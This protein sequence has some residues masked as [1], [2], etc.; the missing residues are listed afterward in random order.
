MDNY[1]RRFGHDLGNG[2]YDF[3][4]ARQGTIVGLLSIGCLFGAL[5]AGRLADT[6]GRRLAISFFAFFA[7]IGTAIEISSSYHW[8]QFAMGRFVTGI[9]IG[10]MSVVVPMYQSESTPAVIRGV[11]VSSY[12]LLITLGIWT[13][14]MVNYGTNE[15][16]SSAS[17]RI[18]NG[19][20]FAWALVLGSTILFLPESPRY[21]YSR[22]RIEE[23]RETIAKLVGLPPTSNVV[24]KQIAD[25]QAK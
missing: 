24:N 18:P 4:A 11:I 25:L 9:S 13:A 12:Q 16:E 14:E 2:K 22:G 8:V 23:A 7:C 21:A 15:M 3:S 20:T 6:I 1:G 17:W 19:L 5:V 10:A